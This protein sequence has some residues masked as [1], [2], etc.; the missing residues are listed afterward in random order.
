MSKCY[1]AFY[2]PG[3][4]WTPGKSIAQQ[5]L[6]D[7]VTYLTDLH[8]R[9]VVKMGGPFADGEAGL[10]ILEA[11]DFAEASRIINEDPAVQRGILGVQVREWNR[12]V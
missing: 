5:P 3:E 12:V 8:T 4:N 10:V 9:N 11:Y 2:Q 1:A 6:G 7:H